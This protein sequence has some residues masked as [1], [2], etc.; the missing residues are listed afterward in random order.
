M[1]IGPHLPSQTLATSSWVAPIGGSFVPVTYQ[2]GIA[3]SE[4]ATPVRG[5]WA[6]EVSRGGLYS[7]KLRRWP[8][9]AVA[10]A[11]VA[12][13]PIDPR[14]NGSARLFISPEYADLDS[15]SLSESGANFVDLEQPIGPSD[16]EAEFI[17]P[18]EAGPV[19]LG[20]ELTGVREFAAGCDVDTA[21]AACPEVQRSPYYAVVTAIPNCSD[22]IDNDGD[23]LV[24][25][26]SDPGCPDAGGVL[27]NPKCQDGLDNDRQPGI[28][29]DGGAAANGGAPLGDADPDCSSPWRNRE[30]PGCGLGF[31][32]VL[33]APLVARRLRRRS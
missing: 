4:P 18:L 14:G 9:M 11:S 32:L 13:R 28:D 23:T 6:L 31:E 20:G 7:I 27:E 16:A 30:A 15:L 19:F 5:F 22:G 2:D 21:P 1:S 3:T 17:V 25:F 33:L 10:P 24:D 29:F 12:D 8:G 26:P